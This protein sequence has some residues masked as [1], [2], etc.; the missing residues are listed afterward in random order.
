MSIGKLSAGS[1]LLA[2]AMATAAGAD[3][4]EYYRGKT[5]QFI[6]GSSAGGGFDT[7][8]RLIARHIGDH[9]PGKPNVVAQNMP[10]AGGVR[11]GD[12]IYFTAPKDGT[13][14][15]LIDPGVFNSQL[16]GETRIRFDTAKFTWIGRMVNNSPVLY[17][18]YQS[19]IQKTE[20]IFTKETIIAASGPTP[21]LNYLL[22]NTVLNAKIKTIVGYSGSAAASLAMERGEV[23]GLSQPWPILKQTKA[24][25]VNEKKIIP[26]LQTGAEIHPELPNVPRMIDLT[27]NDDDRKLFEFFAL[28]SQ[29]GRSVMAP[30][31]LP[32]E[33]TKE[34]RAGFQAMIKSAKFLEE[35]E[36]TQ[37]DLEPMTGEELQKL[38]AEGA[39]FPP[40]V[41]ER[42]REITALDAKEAEKQK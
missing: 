41:L 32:A 23:H 11:A 31:E 3:A 7:Q 2:L 9:L 5:V 36:K 22:L 29:L 13:V 1:T 4:Q 25:W 15:G 34:L 14:I 18:W 24:D 16:L 30:P 8:S 37:T 10:G 26:I 19:P 35:A 28:P 33:R 27:K 17:T 38:L 12:F 39:S 20:D 40:H 21:R 42:A 6:I